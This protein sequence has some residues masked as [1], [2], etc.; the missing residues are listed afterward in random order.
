MLHVH[1][2]DKRVNTEHQTP[3]VV[4]RY[5]SHSRLERDKSGYALLLR[6]ELNNCKQ[7]I[8]PDNI[9]SCLNLCPTLRKLFLASSLSMQSKNGV[10]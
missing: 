3:T 8:P 1:K 4:D 10:R 9:V 5:K 7:A 6:E 2:R